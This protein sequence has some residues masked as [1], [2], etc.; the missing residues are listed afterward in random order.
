[1]FGP[2][3]PVPYELR[4]PFSNCSKEDNTFGSV[5]VEPIRAKGVQNVGKISK[6]TVAICNTAQ[7]PTEM[8]IT[9]I[10]NEMLVQPC[11]RVSLKEI[12]HD[13]VPTKSPHDGRIN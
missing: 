11:M 4:D 10:N 1:M 12:L 6:G 13:E 7:V 3:N 8:N 5:N 2:A 9:C